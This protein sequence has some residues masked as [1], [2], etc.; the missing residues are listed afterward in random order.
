MK[1]VDETEGKFREHFGVEPEVVVVA[2]GRV[3]L[4]GEHTDYNDGYVVPAAID[5]YIVVA[6]GKRSDRLAYIHSVDYNL[7]HR[8]YTPHVHQTR[9]LP[10]ADYPKGILCFLRR[11]G[12]VVHGLNFCVHGDIPQGAGL[13]SSGA[14]EVASAYAFTRLFHLDVP[15]LDLVRLC[16]RA[17][18]DFVGVQCGVMDQFAA[19]RGK[20]NHALFLDCRSLNYELIPLPQSVRVV[21]CDTRVKRALSKSEYN[22]RRLECQEGVRE[23]S[24]VLP[25]IRSLRDVSLDTFLR[26]QM[27]LHWTLRKRCRHVISENERVLQGVKAL[28]EGDVGLFGKLM[29]DS[30]VSL[31]NDYEVSCRELDAAV[32]IAMEVDGVYGA[33]M[34]GAGFGG[35]VICLVQ[36]G[37]VDLLAR[38]VQKEYTKVFAVEPEIYACS[39]E[40]GAR[41]VKQ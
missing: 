29:L 26:H 1:L 2:P 6:V 8:Y 18:N 38:T 41:V 14:L 36:Q 24:G 33:R 32:D 15:D 21:V 35:S 30:H 23:L 16:Q 10:W 5:R 25:G 34:T 39:V 20:K 4:M 11:Y 13:S 31:R 3:N 22:T 40:D 9:S 19:M 17:E 7:T 27:H 12:A 28:R 37:Q